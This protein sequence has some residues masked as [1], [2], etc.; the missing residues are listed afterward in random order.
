[1]VRR[2]A[3]KFVGYCRVSTSE[4][5]SGGDSLATQRQQIT[6]YAMMQGWEIDASLS[7]RACRARCRSRIGP[8]ASG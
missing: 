5:A 7:M 8:R 2:K 4:Q 1:M 3:R 6:G